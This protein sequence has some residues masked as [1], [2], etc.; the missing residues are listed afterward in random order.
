[1]SGFT[2]PVACISA[3]PEMSDFTQS[4]LHCLQAMC[5]AV[6]P[7]MFRALTGDPF[8]SSSIT[9]P[10]SP[11]EQAMCSGVLFLCTV[12]KVKFP[13]LSTHLSEDAGKELTLSQALTSARVSQR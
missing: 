7:S 11:A 13:Y 9:N 1:M 8:I 4:S 2:V 3:P 6:K 5:S 12:L 10:T